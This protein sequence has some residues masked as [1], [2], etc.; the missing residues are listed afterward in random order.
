MSVRK[1]EP[2]QFSGSVWEKK[3]KSKRE[4]ERDQEGEGEGNFRSLGSK[5]LIYHYASNT[6]DHSSGQD[7][8]GHAQNGELYK[9]RAACPWSQFSG[10]W[11]NIRHKCR[12]G[13]RNKQEQQ[14]RIETS[15]DPKVPLDSPSEDCTCC[16]R[17]KE[18]PLW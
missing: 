16:I 3:R 6:D 10:P 9:G 12:N 17:H 5:E 7:R 14:R 2:S 13:S 8:K 1:S 4:G 11:H 15:K 18:L